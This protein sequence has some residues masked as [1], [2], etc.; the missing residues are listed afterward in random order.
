M[1]DRLRSSRAERDIL[2]ST[3]VGS[4]TPWIIAAMTFAIV[5]V[6]CGG[7][8]IAHASR[9]LRNAIESRFT[10]VVP[11]G[12][13]DVALLAARARQITGISSVEPVG[14]A[15]LRRML[16]QWLGPT[17]ESEDLPVPSMIDFDV[18]RPADLPRI[19]AELRRLAPQSALSSHAQN[20]APFARSLRGL[21]W[22]AALLVALL[23]VAAGAAVVLSARSA[24]AGHRATIGIL[25]G[26]GATDTQ[27]TRLFVRRIALDTL[28]GSTAGA[29]AAA[30]TIA[31]IAST[32]KWL[33]DFGGMALGVLDILLLCVIPLA[34][35]L[36]TTWAVRSAILS[37]LEREL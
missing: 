27:V 25:H 22:T 26:I 18:A 11:A 28:I 35:T 23:A 13:G 16:G 31:L 6:A 34:L 33:N 12:G 32:A 14:E 10:L 21:Q 37:S 30:V 8:M 19:A 20:V 36:V 2:G 5:L 3:N 17:A 15:D 29:V 7:L 4:V 1:I 24:L 9:T